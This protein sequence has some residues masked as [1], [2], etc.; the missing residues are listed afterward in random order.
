MKLESWRG[1]LPPLS[2]LDHL[3]II[4]CPSSICLV[5]KNSGYVSIPRF[6]DLVDFFAVRVGKYII[7]GSYGYTCMYIYICIMYI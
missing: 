7:H 6:G 1:T 4:V 2:H 3:N 5:K